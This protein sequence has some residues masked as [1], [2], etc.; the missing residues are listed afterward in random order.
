MDVEEG[1]EKA[2]EMEEEERR[3]VRNW[4][5]RKK[6]WKEPV[7]KLKKKDETNENSEIVIMESKEI[8]RIDWMIWRKQ[9]RIMNSKENWTE[10]N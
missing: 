9:G 1:N 8:K 2:K 5:A 10:Q 7:K 4:F 6:K 3:H